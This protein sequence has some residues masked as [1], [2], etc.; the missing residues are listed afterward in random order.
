[1]GLNKKQNNQTKVKIKNRGRSPHFL[2]IY[3][4]LFLFMSNC[5]KSSTRPGRDWSRGIRLRIAQRC[6][7]NPTRRGKQYR[8]RIERWGKWF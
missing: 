1:M 5:L 3:Y 7:R 4:L 2:I 8:R 6:A